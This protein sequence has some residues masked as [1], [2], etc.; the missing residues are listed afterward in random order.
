MNKNLC[1]FLFII[2]KI[3]FNLIFK[4]VNFIKF[5][6]KNQLYFNKSKMELTQNKTMAFSTT[7]GSR[8]NNEDLEFVFDN[9]K[10]ACVLMLDGHSGILMKDAFGNKL[11]ET[12]IDF[13]NNSDSIN[14]I[15]AII[16]TVKSIYYKTLEYVDNIP[17]T[18]SGT[19]M[20][21]GIFDKENRNLF[22]FQVG[23]SMIFMSNPE[24]GD[25]V[26][27]VKIF[28]SDDLKPAKDFD[29]GYDSCVTNVHD[30]S[31]QD[32]IDLYKRYCEEN[33]VP[34]SVNKRT[35]A[36]S[37]ENR[38]LA[39]IRFD[40]LP[41]P[42]RTIEPLS[43][44][45]KNKIEFIV[46][47]QRTPEIT[48]WSFGKD[49]KLALCA[50]CDGF[51]S[52]LAIPTTEQISKVLMNPG[53]YI[54][55]P[56]ILE[57]TLLGSWID[58]PWWNESFIKPVDEDWNKDPVLYANKLLHHIA[59]DKSWK[60]AVVFS[61]NRIEELRNKL[62]QDQIRA[63]LNLQECVDLAV[64]IPISLASDDNVSC[65]IVLL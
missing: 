45:K 20:S 32:E 48:V 2:T 18:T 12:L 33:N 55:D 29:L 39:K 7:Q 10:F 61:I 43:F 60:D 40:N 31:D 28:A 21:L 13:F 22:T 65:C 25:I 57:N 11:T 46:N 4:L 15:S 5:E 35:D 23:D 30:F 36:A 41:E 9:H 16:D 38:Y 58:K 17:I 44:Y 34:M 62:P 49:D 26:N 1:K 6:I 52:K 8:S 63:S 27:G 56:L 50:V 24:N 51:V 53:L 59:P 64:Q 42:S 3:F 47:L 14:D 54:Q 37:I 19:T